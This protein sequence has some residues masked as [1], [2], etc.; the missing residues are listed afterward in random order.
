MIPLTDQ[1]KCVEREIALRRKAYPKWVEQRR[2]GWTMEKMAREI[3]A[4]EAVLATLV[5][6]AKDRQGELPIIGPNLE[7]RMEPSSKT[8]NPP[9]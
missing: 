7:G 9:R 5:D 6:A 8:H 2:P 1:I 4:M 3:A